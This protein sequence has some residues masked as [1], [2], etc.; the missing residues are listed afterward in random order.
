MKYKILQ[1]SDIL[2]D[3]DRYLLGTN[4]YR[5]IIPR[6]FGKTVKEQTAGRDLPSNYFVRLI[7]RKNIG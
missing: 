7:K 6:L 1:S 2:R 3:G 4:T 5:L